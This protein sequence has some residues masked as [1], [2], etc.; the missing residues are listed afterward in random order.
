M[1]N[2][3]CGITGSATAS[4]AVRRALAPNI[5]PGGKRI[6]LHAGDA[7][8]TTRASLASPEAGPL[9]S[10]FGHGAIRANFD[11]ADFFENFARNH[12]NAE[13]GMRNHGERNRLGCGSARPRAEHLAG[14][15]AKSVGRT[16]RTP[17]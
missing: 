14:G 10:Q 9:P 4:A 7:K 3:E 11:L 6:G 12:M 16:R 17:N 15:Q 8:P 2:A 13:R 1:R 5:S